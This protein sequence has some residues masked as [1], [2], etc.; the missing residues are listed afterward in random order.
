MSIFHLLAIASAVTLLIASSSASSVKPVKLAQIFDQEMIGADVAYFEQVVGPARNTYDNTKIYK[1]DGCEV[2]ATISGISV[3][4]LRVDLS[5]Q[6]TFNLNKFLP[7]FSNRFPP[8]HVMTFG[9]FDSITEGTGRFY[10]DCLTQCGNAADPVIFEH[11]YGSRADLFLEVVLEAV[12]ASSP[13]LSAA[14]TWK[15]AMEKIE[16]ENWVI[17]AKF[18]CTRK[19]DAIA[20]RAFQDVTISA[21]TIGYDVQVPRCES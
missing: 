19:Y 3:R 8:P 21:I 4:A 6:C 17:D 7:N 5:P 14:H 18:N 11:W 9:K 2:T 15:T 13:V 20:H 16:G 12:L 10:A 1:V